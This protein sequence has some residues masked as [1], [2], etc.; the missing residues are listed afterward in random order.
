MRMSEGGN[1]R[2]EH[3]VDVRGNGRGEMERAGRG[4]GRVERGNGKRIGQRSDESW[5]D[6]EA[7]NQ[8]KSS[9]APMADGETESQSER[10]GV[11]V[12]ESGDEVWTAG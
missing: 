5:E 4:E 8:A 1:E 11:H 6:V 12:R 2:D 7:D 10:E 9:H 3:R